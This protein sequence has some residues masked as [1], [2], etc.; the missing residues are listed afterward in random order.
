MASI[1]RDPRGKSPFWYCAYRLPNGRRTFRSTKLKD[2]AAALKFCRGLEYASHE[3]RAGRLTESRALELVSE[4]VEQTTG[5]P[6]R[7][8]TVEGWLREWCKGKQDTKSSATASK[9]E[10][11]IE[12]FIESLGPRAGLNLR[13][14]LPRD[15]LRWRESE[16]ASGK[17]PGT[18]NDY[19]G[20][21][22]S[23][24]SAARKQGLITHNPAEAVERLRTESESTRRPFT[25]EEIQALLRSSKGDWH[26]AILVALYTGTRLHDAA[27]LRWESI[28]LDGHWISYKASKTRQRIKVPMHD[29]LHG[30]LKKQIRGI[31]AAPLFPELAGKSTS[32][33]SREFTKVMAR[34]D[35]HAEIVRDRQGESGRLVSSLGFHSLR[36]AYASLMANRG[37]AEEVRMKLAGHSSADVHAGYTHHEAS[38]LRAAI[39]QLP[40]LLEVTR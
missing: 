40:S 1:H 31:K 39:A 11:A 14:V 15:V 13:Q 23:A 21:V 5:E 9:Y 2:R 16:V 37:V 12:R 18:C 38:V 34:A 22:R 20:I 33:L 8:Y 30:W 17:H 10:T 36:H 26:G 35:V 7:S 27:N 6:L 25:V 28:D 24:F 32:I 29:A 4:I 19:L 3:S